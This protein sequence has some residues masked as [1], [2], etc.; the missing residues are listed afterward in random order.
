MRPALH[1][2][3]G[4]DSM[5]WTLFSIRNTGSKPSKGSEPLGGLA[6]GKNPSAA[7][8][9]NSI[10]RLYDKQYALEEQK[11]IVQIERVDMASRGYEKERR[12]QENKST[13]VIEIISEWDVNSTKIDTSLCCRCN[14]CLS[15]I[16]I[17]AKAQISTR[18]EGLLHGYGVCA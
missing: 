8:H 9:G 6:K 7:G 15:Q 1:K 3:F 12:K 11:H 13:N 4:S 18:P 5:L 2:I 14:R 17:T 10:Q 16:D